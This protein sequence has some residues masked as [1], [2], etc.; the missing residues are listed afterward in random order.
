MR[1]TT[2]TLGFLGGA[3]LLLLGVA[4]CSQSET[5]FAPPDID[6]DEV[7]PGGAVSLSGQVTRTTA[8][9]LPGNGMLAAAWD[10]FLLPLRYAG[11]RAPRGMYTAACNVDGETPRVFVS[12]NVESTVTEPPPEGETGP[13]WQDYWWHGMMLEGEYRAG[14]G[15]V[16]LRQVSRPDCQ[17]MRGVAVAPDCS[18][19]A[20][21]CMKPNQESVHPSFAGNGPFD[22][23]LTADV[24]NDWIDRHPRNGGTWP[25]EL[26]LYVW[27]GGDI[28]AEPS[29]FVVHGSA[30]SSWHYM[31]YRLVYGDDGT[32][33]ILTK[34]YA[35]GHEGSSLM[36]IDRA[37]N[38]FVSGRSDFWGGCG[39]S[40]GH[41][42][43]GF[44]AYSASTGRYATH[45]GGDWDNG[46]HENVSV[47]YRGIE[48]EGVG[49]KTLYRTVINQQC[50]ALGG[51]GPIVPMNDG[52]YMLAMTTNVDDEATASMFEVSEHMM[53]ARSSV[54]L[55]RVDAAGDVV[56]GPKYIQYPEG[57]ALFGGWLT[58]AILAD[59]GNGRYLFGY[60]VAGVEDPALTYTNGD[61]FGF[62]GSRYNP[63]EYVLFE[64][65]E[66]GD[67]VSEETVTTQVGWGGQDEMV[68]LGPGRVGWAYVP[69]PTESEGSN[70]DGQPPANSRISELALFV[71]ESSAP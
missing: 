66:N 65:D 3:L 50:C 15:I 26:W 36:V 31:N 62:V 60:G 8:T 70:F 21:L 63:S 13:L 10:D 17:E 39:G 22:H 42:T 49:A 34:A 52:G 16:P 30:G 11:F 5:Q 7:E 43:Q 55:M 35:G 27:E 54:A 14:E 24:D 23:D 57:G 46:D 47:G 1:A 38:T 69:D 2:S 56:W 25:E 59:L 37:T 41:P 32:L 29:R 61:D 20:A 48:I 53:R 71:Y 40:A 67:R 12:A 45:C 51:P 44:L 58:H 19:V 9:N 18:Y 33:G 6:V 28:G 4:A 64:V 68:N